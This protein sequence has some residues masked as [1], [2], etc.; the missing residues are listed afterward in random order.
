M[1]VFKDERSSPQ[2][3]QYCHFSIGYGS[4]M[5]PCCLKQI[6]REDYVRGARGRLGGAVGMATSCPRDA[7]EAHN[8]IEAKKM[9]GID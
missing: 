3:N 9:R 6:S 8:I 4:L 1:I 5:K 2:Q 7:D